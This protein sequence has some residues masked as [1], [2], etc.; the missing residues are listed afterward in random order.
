MAYT[1]HEARLIATHE[2]DMLLSRTSS[3]PAQAGGADNHQAQRSA[4]AAGTQRHEDVFTRSR[5][6]LLALIQ[7]AFGG[8]AAEELFFGEISTGRVRIRTYATTVAAQM[9]G[10]AGMVGSLINMSV[11]TGRPRPTP[12][13]WAGADATSRAAVEELLDTRS[14]SHAR[15]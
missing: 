3:P 5:S 4:R 11:L 9:V 2:A 13:S 1:D 10:A 8:M 14:R 7:I 12:T 15:S 6:E